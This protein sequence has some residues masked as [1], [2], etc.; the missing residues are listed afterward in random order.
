LAFAGTMSCYTKIFTNGFVCGLPEMFIDAMLLWQPGGDLVRRVPVDTNKTF[1]TTDNICLPS[2]SWVGWQGILNFDGWYTANDFVASCSGWIASARCQIVSTTTWYAC[3][4]HHGTDRRKINCLWTEWRER[5]KDPDTELPEGWTKRLKKEGE[6][7]TCE[8]PPDGYGKYVY[9]FEGSENPTFWYPLPLG[10]ATEVLETDRNAAYLCSE[11]QTAFAY[12][13]GGVSTT[14]NRMGRSE[15]RHAYISLC[16]SDQKWIGILTL[17]TTDYF[18]KKGVDLMKE[19]FEVQLIAIS[20]GFVM[21]GLEWVDSYVEEYEM[22]ER[23]S[24]GPKYEFVNVLWISWD[25]AVARREGLGRV[26]KVY[27]ERL[28]VRVLEVILG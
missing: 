19:S 18:E 7:F 16:S 9:Q 25:G 11:V 1:T 15:Q 23:P 20:E 28:G 14:R 3:T 8:N 12:T 24:E 2:W 21:N 17:H 13:L 10:N 22:E 26:A 4:T 6:S 5:Y 27:W